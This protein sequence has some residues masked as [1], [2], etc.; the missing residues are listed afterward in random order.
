[1][2][3]AVSK[4]SALKSFTLAR[5]GQP[6]GRRHPRRVDAGDTGLRDGF[7]LL[8]N[9]ALAYLTGCGERRRR[10]PTWSPPT[11]SSANVNPAG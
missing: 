10:R 6:G 1:L 2:L 11:R 8:V 3:S 5:G 7:N 4:A 9:A